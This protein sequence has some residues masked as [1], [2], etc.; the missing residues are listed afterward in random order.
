MIEASFPL[1]SCIIL[2]PLL[3]ALV[4]GLLPDSGLAKKAGV[5]IAGVELV[6]TVVLFLVFN[7]DN[8]GFQWVERHAWIPSL[9]INY[10][11]GID[12][13][14][15]LFLPMSA[16]LTLMAL[17]ASWNTVRHLSRFHLALLLALEGITM[18]VFCALDMVLF[19]LFWELTLPVIFFLIGLWGIGAERR[20]AATKYTV[21]MLFGG[22]ALLA[23]IVIVA[24]N[25]TGQL[26]D[27]MAQG[28]V[29]SLPELLKSPLPEHLQTAVFF[30]LLFGFA[31]KAPLMPFHSWLPTVA[32]EAA[33][34]TTALLVGLKL[35]VY[36]LIRFALPLAP[37]AAVEYSWALGILGGVTLIYAGLIALQQN[38]LRRLLAYASI[39]HVGLVVVGIAA[40]NMQGMQGAIFQLFNFTLVASSLM[41]IA[42]FIQQRLGS[43]EALH[44]SGLA[45]VMPQL[46]CGYFLFMLASIGLPGT[47][48]F[49]AELLLLMGA[50]TSHT[51]LAFIALAGAVLSAAYMLSFSRRVFWGAVSKQLGQMTDIR[52]RELLVLVIPAVLVLVIGFYPRGIVKVSRAAAEQWLS[53]I[54]DQQGLKSGSVAEGEI[55][56]S[57]Q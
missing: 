8:G 34:H 25:P 52:L 30:L 6:L 38:N 43:T 57:R 22:A 49:P 39:S 44:L 51:S 10:L 53:L 40:L 11:I 13:I 28:L 50:L 1:L 45:K 56:P 24:L 14:S 54:L 41:L 21:F 20:L 2:W 29:F 18:G 16:L 55:N 32:M 12:G 35:G 5:V 42:G 37:A 46:S 36:G 3:G 9:H 4:V 47:S 23:A 33:P 17:G 19:F 31:V 48:G 27:G 7:P 26:Q 15:V